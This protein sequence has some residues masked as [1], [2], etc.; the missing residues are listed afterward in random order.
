MNGPS[1]E[2]SKAVIIN[3]RTQITQQQNLRQI[4][5]PISCFITSSGFML[6]CVGVRAK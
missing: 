6:C 1:V 5:G 2:P 4:S 3:I